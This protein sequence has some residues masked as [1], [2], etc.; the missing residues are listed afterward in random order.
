VRDPTDDPN[1]L[2]GVAEHDPGS[3]T[4]D[5]QTYI[6][7]MDPVVKPGGR[8]DPE[9]VGGF[10]PDS[11]SDEPSPPRPVTGGSAD[12]ALAERVRRELLEDATT[13][14]LDLEVEVQDGVAF[15]R[16]RVNDLVD[17]DNALE[18]AGRIPGIVDVVDELTIAE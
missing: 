1:D 14:D 3:A 6:P 7:P 11:M 4:E 5:A 8:G 9:I 15:L 12:E 16:G 2:G 10:S 13:T 18:V 17:L